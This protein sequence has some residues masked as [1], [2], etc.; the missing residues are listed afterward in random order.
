MRTV[1]Q[2]AARIH[3]TG[4]DIL[5]DIV[6]HGHASGR[7][8]SMQLARAQHMSMRPL[9]TVNVTTCNSIGHSLLLLLL[10]FITPKQHNIQR[11]HKT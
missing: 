9:A 6:G 2:L 7:L 5:A 8:F 3:S 10:L 4:R 11:K 1:S